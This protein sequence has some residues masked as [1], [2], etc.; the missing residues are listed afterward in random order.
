MTI[1]DPPGID[2]RRAP[3]KRDRQEYVRGYLS[4]LSFDIP[5]AFRLLFSRKADLYVV[6]P[7]PTTVAVVRVIAWLRRTP[8]VVDAADL[9]SDAA[10]MVTSSRFVLG[11]LRWLEKWALNGARH[12]FA[13]HEPLVKRFRDVGIDA[14]ATAIGF[15]ADTNDFHY[16][17]PSPHEA[18][19]FVY[20]GTHSEWHGASI[21]VDAFARVAA[22]HPGARLLFVGNGEERDALRALA[23]RLGLIDRVEFRTPIPP[24]QLNM[25]LSSATASLA[26]L[27][28]GQ[29]YDY[30][31]TT[32]I[33]S[34]L[35]AGCPVIFTGVGPT[36][37]F[38]READ[39]RDVGV[40]IDYNIA[41]VA[42]AMNVAAARPLASEARERLASW[43]AD[44]YSLAQIARKVVDVSLASSIHSQPRRTINLGERPPYPGE[45][46]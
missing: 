11:A 32:K 4:Y 42:D 44:R 33:Y 31:F 20:A 2:V 3:V 22:Q 38:L 27:R 45:T 23:Q 8:Y 36:V 17:A 34:S 37:A 18:P 35:A 5:L 40:A 12:L 46:P 39:N 19:L 13:A 16:V 41:A 26:S 25:L 10:A 7:P 21:F 29:G 43:T 30:A 6:E 14:P 28:P 9:W 24:T 1:D 15:G